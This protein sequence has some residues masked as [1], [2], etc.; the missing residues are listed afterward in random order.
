MAA[1]RR[2]GGNR[3]EQAMYLIRLFY[4]LGSNLWIC[5]TKVMSTIAADKP[6]FG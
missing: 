6:D 5:Y 1:I 2:P 4:L 3:G